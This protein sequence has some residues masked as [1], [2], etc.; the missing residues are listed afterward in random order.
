MNLDEIASVPDPVAPWVQA[1]VLLGFVVL[2]VRGIVVRAY[3][4]RARPPSTRGRWRR[5]LVYAIGL[6][7]GGLAGLALALET[8]GLITV[9]VSLGL[10]ASVLGVPLIERRLRLGGRHVPRKPGHDEDV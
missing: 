9:G 6:V 1:V 8:D 5:L 3:E 2:A 4:V 7:A 10:G